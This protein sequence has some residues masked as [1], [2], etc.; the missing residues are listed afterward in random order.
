MNKNTIC[1]YI[2]DFKLVFVQADS[3]SRKYNIA[4]LARDVKA[5]FVDKHEELRVETKNLDS[6]FEKF[7]KEFKVIE[8]GGGLINNDKG[9]YLLIYRHEKWDLP[10]GKLDKKEKPDAAAVRECQEECGLN[11]IRLGDFLMH[12]YHVYPYKGNW[13]LKKT[14][15]YHMQCNETNLKPQLEEH[16]TRVEWMNREQIRKALG[17]TYSNIRDVLASAGLTGK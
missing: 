17:N 5:S 15:W 9:E 14:W 6:D 16:I 12:T 10:K 11:H 2:G 3:P 8:A 1:V 7:C 13:A 4:A